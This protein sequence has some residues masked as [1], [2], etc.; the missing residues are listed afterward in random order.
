MTPR[1]FINGTLAVGNPVVLAADAANHVCRVLRLK[2]GSE[3]TVFN[4]QGGEFKGTIISVVKPVKVLLDEF[5]VPDRESKLNLRLIQGISRADRMD[6]TIQ[7]AVELGIKTIQPVVT[8]LGEVKLKLDRVTKKMEHWHRVI[9]SAMEQSKRCVLPQLL[10]VKPLAEVK[11]SDLTGIKLV[12]DP[13][14]KAR[15]SEVS[16]D[17]QEL[18]ILVGPEQ[19]LSEAEITRAQASGFYA[20]NLGPRILRTETAAIAAISALQARWGDF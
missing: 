12:L 16:G 1:V 4:G 17:N 6:F 19:G 18:T 13:S 5:F 11:L 15:I 20:V 3:V 9:I 14:A 2:I 10:P 8:K 7:K